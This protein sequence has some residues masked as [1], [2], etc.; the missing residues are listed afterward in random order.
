MSEDEKIGNV[1]N[2]ENWHLILSEC[3]DRESTIQLN[4]TTDTDDESVNSF[5]NFKTLRSGRLTTEI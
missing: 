5:I 2:D 3:H 4:N 1:Q